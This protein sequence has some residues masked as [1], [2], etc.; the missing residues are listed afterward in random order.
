MKFE[1]GGT[2]LGMDKRGR[3]AVLT[4]VYTREPTGTNAAGKGFLIIDYLKETASAKEYLIEVA[5]RKVAYSPFNLCM[6]EPQTNHGYEALYYCRGTEQIN[7]EGPVSIA[8]GVSGFANHPRS[9]PYIKTKMGINM[10]SS[11]IT[12]NKHRQGIEN[13][14]FKLL[15]NNRQMYPDG[16]MQNQSGVLLHRHQQQ[17]EIFLW[18]EQKMSSIFADIPKFGT[19]MQ[20]VIFVDYDGHV[21][22]TERTRVSDRASNCSEDSDYAVLPEPSLYTWDSKMFEFDVKYNC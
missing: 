19:R 2:W 18:E 17:K 15:C 5:E 4:N 1:E 7:G 13:E 8:A 10:F 3:I 14:A 20:T 6:F 22:F 12:N 9:K 11:I 16:Q 21:H